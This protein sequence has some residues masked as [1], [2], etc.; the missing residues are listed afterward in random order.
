MHPDN[1]SPSLTKPAF[2]LLIVAVFLAVMA[3]FF[4]YHDPYKDV[5]DNLVTG[6]DLEAPLAAN[7][8]SGRGWRG[9]G[10]GVA[11][12]AQGGFDG[13]G[14]VRLGTQPG[15]GSS[16][17]YTVERPAA[18]QFLRVSG[19]LRTADIVQGR[20]NWNS[21]RLLLAFTQR[22]GQHS[23]HKICDITGSSAWQ[24][25]AGVVPVPHSAVAAQVRVENLAA[26]GALWVDDL[27][28]TPAVEKSSAFFWRALFGTLWCATLIYCAWMSR[29]QDRPLGPAIVLIAIAITAGVAAPQ[30]TI[31]RML[32]RGADTVNGLVVGEPFSE[33]PPA[34]GST[35]SRPRWTHEVKRALGWPFDLMFTVKKVGHF[36]LFGLLA[37]FAFSS[38]ARRHGR[39]ESLSSATE[40]ATTGAALLLFAA[41]AE[42]VQFLTTSR[43]PSLTDWVIDAGGVLLGGAVALMWSRA[44]AG[45]PFPRT[46]VP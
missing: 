10:P 44:Q 33:A 3:L 14:G 17:S 2:G 45:L 22:D 34:A 15:R 19:R 36:V 25:C 7:G 20:K 16:L 39:P 30:S 13:S 24:L 29:L 40:F 11:W 8:Q 5:G 9:R 27:R 43:T 1:V 21:A 35:D 38:T 37:F 12:E 28:L 31:D 18:S 32:D 41:A 23:D 26:S 46:N 6:G 4:T 42:V